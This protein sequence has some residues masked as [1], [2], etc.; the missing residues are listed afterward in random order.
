MSGF[1]SIP[2]EDSC[3]WEPLPDAL[4]QQIHQFQ[5]PERIHAFGNVVREVVREVAIAVSIPRE[6][7]CFWEL[8][9]LVGTVGCSRFQSPERIH[10]FGNSGKLRIGG[11]DTFQSPER[12]HAFGNSRQ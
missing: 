11:K 1:V 12:I 5:S 10:A 3:F 6:D 7:S 4:A 8:H 9:R 2:R